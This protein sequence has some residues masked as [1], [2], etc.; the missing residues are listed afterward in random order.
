MSFDLT[1]NVEQRHEMF[2]RRVVDQTG[3]RPKR[4]TTTLV[5]VESISEDRYSPDRVAAKSRPPDRCTRMT[6]SVWSTRSAP[7]RSPTG[8]RQTPSRVPTVAAGG[9]R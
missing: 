3:R 9:W 1:A 6:C 4:R 8:A 2:V 5:A 7:S